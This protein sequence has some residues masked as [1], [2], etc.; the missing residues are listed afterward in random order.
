[1]SFK[2]IIID[3]EP[4]AINVVK[5]Y[6]SQFTELNLIKTFKNALNAAS[7]LQENTVDIIFLDIN[8]PVL[9][10]LEFLDGLTTRPFV[11]ITTAHEEYALK[12]FEYQAIGYLVKPIPFPSFVKV[13]T[14]IL[15]LLNNKYSEPS[16]LPVKPSLFVKISKKKLQK[17]YLEDILVVE[18]MKDYIRI[19]T[20]LGNFIVHQSLGSFTDELP[21]HAFLRIHRSFTIAIDKIESIESNQLQIDG[22]KYVIGRQY[23]NEVRDTLL[24]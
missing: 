10:G 2:V 1:M 15:E 6:V 21:P 4:L 18:S 23:L 12:G 8:M 20:T 3:D 13:V 14:R 17:I 11:V 24:K 19:K 16:E 9:N 7:F 22:V 5:N